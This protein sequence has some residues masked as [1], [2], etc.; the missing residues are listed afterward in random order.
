MK[1]HWRHN[2][3]EGRYTS[4]QLGQA[5]STN[6]LHPSPPRCCLGL[7]VT[8]GV[9]PQHPEDDWVRDDDWVIPH[10]HLTHPPEGQWTELGKPVEASRGV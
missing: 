10:H 9:Y 6:T 8:L 5:E 2:S 4:G 1:T 7:L 3:A